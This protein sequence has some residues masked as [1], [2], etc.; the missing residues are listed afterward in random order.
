MFF[1]VTN[2]HNYAQKPNYFSSSDKH[3]IFRF[4]RL[5]LDIAEFKASVIGRHKS[6]HDVSTLA[7]ACDNLSFET[8]EH[9]LLNCPLYESE[10]KELSH[11]LS[12]YG[13]HSLSLKLLLDTD[14]S[15]YFPHPLNPDYKS[16]IHKAIFQFITSV[17]N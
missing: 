4:I 10:R 14:I 7:C 6:P 1:E 17:F 9:V 13:V 15:D 16:R 12:L 2:T 3:L 11:L 5:R 8:R